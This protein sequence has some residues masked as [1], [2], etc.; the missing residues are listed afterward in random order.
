MKGLK[1][2]IFCRSKVF[3]T[4]SSVP[5]HSDC[6]APERMILSTSSTLE[7]NYFSVS[8]VKTQM[9]QSVRNCVQSFLAVE[10]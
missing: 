5:C 6:E 1:I 9:K 7:Y 4:M 10:D 2:N 3:Q 8:A